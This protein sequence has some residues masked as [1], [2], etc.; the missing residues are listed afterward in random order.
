MTRA[1]GPE[2]HLPDLPEVQLGGLPPSDAPGDARPPQTWTQG[3]LHG[4][5]NYLP[6]LLMAVLAL[7]TWWLVRNTPSAPPPTPET[8]PRVAPDYTMRGFSITRFGPDG[9]VS[10]R[11]DGDLLRH[12]PQSDQL[13]IDGV[14][15]HATAPDGRVT[16]A[17]A[18]RALANG[19]GSEVQLLGGAEVD[20]MLGDG[21]SLQVRGEFLH[22]FLDAERLRSHLPVTVRQ[23]Q[24]E[25]RAGGLDYDNVQHTLQFLGP[26]RSTWVAPGPA[27]R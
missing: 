19:D 8:A 20:S 22:A 26:V 21:R 10:L 2:L 7:G 17:R 15:I 16:D 24:T 4:L 27:A 23:G 11:I 9:R 1:A 6:L 12:F 5:G 13:E 25:T 18:Q 14:R 3:L